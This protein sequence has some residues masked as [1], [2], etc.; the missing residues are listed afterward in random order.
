MTKNKFLKL[1][2]QF[3]T[4][5]RTDKIK[6]DTENNQTIK[7]VYI[8]KYIFNINIDLTLSNGS[9]TIFRLF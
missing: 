4:Y 1:W 5:D 8:I 3:E 2:S 6:N 7:N 9:N